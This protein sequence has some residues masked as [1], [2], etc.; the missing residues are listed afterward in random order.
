MA[1][2]KGTKN[3]L[4]TKKPGP[5]PKSAVNQGTLPVNWFSNN[6]IN[7]NSNNKGTSKSESSSTVTSREDNEIEDGD[8]NVDL[9]KLISLVDSGILEEDNNSPVNTSQIPIMADFDDDNSDWETDNDDDSDV[10]DDGKQNESAQNNSNNINKDNP[11]RNDNK[12]KK[13]FLHKYFL[14]I[15]ERLVNS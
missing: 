10:E 11:N 6:S 2:I 5:K 4:G 1:R 12:N 15:Q 9:G 3:A 7:N 13:T 8:H 14:S